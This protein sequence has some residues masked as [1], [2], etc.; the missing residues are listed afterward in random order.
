MKEFIIKH[1]LQV[2]FS[3]MLSALGVVMRK[4]TQGLKKERTEQESIKLG[5]QAILRDRLIQSY[6]HYMEVGCCAIHDR[7]NIINMYNQYHNLGANGVVDCLIEKL[8][9]L[10]VKNK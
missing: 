1:W 8:L 9:E 3:L 4:I 2:I 10:P 7:D 6:N 5:V